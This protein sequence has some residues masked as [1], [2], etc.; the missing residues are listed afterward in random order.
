ME[1]C[2]CYSSSREGAHTPAFTQF[3]EV[4][5]SNRHMHKHQDAGSDHPRFT[6]LAAIWENFNA[7]DIPAGAPP[8]QRRE[9]QR[10]FIA[11]AAAALMLVA[12][13]RA[14]GDVDGQIGNLQAE[15]TAWLAL[16]GAR[17]SRKT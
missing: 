2:S 3:S 4:Q 13:A 11:G 9:M 8:S 10:A 15:L 17:R 14:C 6:T 16:S 7:T 12:D 1:R 5:R